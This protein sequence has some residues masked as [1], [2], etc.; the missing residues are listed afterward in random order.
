MPEFDDLVRELNDGVV[1]ARRIRSA[2]P[3]MTLKGARRRIERRAGERLHQGRVMRSEAIFS[4]DPDALSRERT[5]VLRPVL[6][7]RHSNLLNFMK[8]PVTTSRIRRAFGEN[9]AQATF[10]L[11]THGLVRR[12]PGNGPRGPGAERFVAVRGEP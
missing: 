10:R 8:A 7:R 6:A 9:G 2:L 1:R 3:G 5:R 12:I 11:E 4:F